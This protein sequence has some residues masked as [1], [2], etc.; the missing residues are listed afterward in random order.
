MLNQDGRRVALRKRRSLQMY[1]TEA[2]KRKIL[3]RY[4]RGEPEA[5]INSAVRGTRASV[6]EPTP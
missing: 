3:R 6:P 1:L 4:N 2:D 5:N